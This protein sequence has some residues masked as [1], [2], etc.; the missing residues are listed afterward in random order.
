M[1]AKAEAS[2]PLAL[3]LQALQADEH[4]TALEEQAR[5]LRREAARLRATSAAV[6]L[7][8]NAAA[9]LDAAVEAEQA[10]QHAYD[11]AGAAERE[12]LR[13]VAL[14][15]RELEAAQDA[16]ERARESGAEP[17]E[18]I[19]ADEHM[20]SA[21]RVL[22]HELAALAAAEGAR[23]EARLSLDR[24]RETV[25]QARAALAEA[26]ANAEHP[27]WVDPCG[28]QGLFQGWVQSLVPGLQAD[29]RRSGLLA[30]RD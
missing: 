20:T 10:A 7:R 2:R 17:A 5:G 24:A 29:L 26:E 13:R 23:V 6:Q 28:T 15:E 14:A 1:T 21:G 18:L 3:E 9:A 4:A 25:R 8:D 11:A 22:E 16:A 19:E 30:H 27:Q 12:A